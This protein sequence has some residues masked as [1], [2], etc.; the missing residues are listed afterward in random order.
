MFAVVNHLQF[1][2][3]VDEIQ[4]K[5]E[6]EGL[7]LLASNKGFINFHLVKE[8][9]DKAIVLILWEDAASAQAGAKSFG[10]TWFTSNIKPHLVGPELR[11]VGEVTLSHKKLSQDN[12]QFMKS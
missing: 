9:E 7:P 5:L 2:R 11:S 10:P 6:K 8:A 1:S 3:P 12:P 4:A